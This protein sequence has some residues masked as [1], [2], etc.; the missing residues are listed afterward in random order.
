MNIKD[1]TVPKSLELLDKKFL[2]TKSEK[3]ESLALEL[4]SFK[5]SSE[6]TAE[7]SWDKFCKIRSSLLKDNLIT[8]ILLHTI[9]F[10]TCLKSQ[11]IKRHEEH[12]F[13]DL[14][15]L[16]DNDTIHDTFDEVFTKQKLIGRRMA[17]TVSTS[18]IPETIVLMG[19]EHTKEEIHFGDQ[20]G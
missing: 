10:N 16:G 15:E 5:L 7:D 20:R 19:D 11:H 13:R 1:K 8:D 17:T 3:T 6:D 4:M 2:Q 18:N 14:L 9:F 12:F